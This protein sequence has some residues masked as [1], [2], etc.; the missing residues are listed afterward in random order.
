MGNFLIIYK[1]ALQLLIL[2]SNQLL[3]HSIDG[4]AFQVFQLE[5]VEKLEKETKLS[6]NFFLFAQQEVAF[7]ANRNIISH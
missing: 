5:K 2:S 1:C 7:S 4:G 6:F 3:E